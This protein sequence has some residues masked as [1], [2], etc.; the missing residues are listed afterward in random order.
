M[1]RD[2][3]VKPQ[4][5]KAVITVGLVSMLLASSTVP[6]SGA[7]LITA[8]FQGAKGSVTC[9]NEVTSPGVAAYT[10]SHDGYSEEA[11]TLGS[12]RHTPCREV[13][14]STEDGFGVRVGCSLNLT[15][16]PVTQGEGATN[17]SSCETSNRLSQG[18][19]SGQIRYYSITLDEWFTIRP[20]VVFTGKSAVGKVTLSGTGP[21]DDGRYMAVFDGKMVITEMWPCGNPT[22][23]VEAK[24]GVFSGVVHI[25]LSTLRDEG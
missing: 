25:G 11:G 12:S 13:D 24:D 2:R 3:V 20:E 10:C 21:S 23:V 6:A 16:D 17:V 8:E 19:S 7:N 5:T 9:H 18:G 14:V 1:K 22:G 15:I 4:R